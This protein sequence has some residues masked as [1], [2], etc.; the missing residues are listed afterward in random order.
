VKFDLRISEE[1]AALVAV[2]VATGTLFA[3]AGD[4]PKMPVDFERGYLAN[5]M[6]VTKEPNNTGLLTGVDRSYRARQRSPR[7]KPTS[8]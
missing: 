4:G 2:L 6:L 7:R 5:S 1:F 3:R 8:S